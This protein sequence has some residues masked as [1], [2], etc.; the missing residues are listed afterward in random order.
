MKN[1]IFYDDLTISDEF[2]KHV[3]KRIKENPKEFT[4]YLTKELKEYPL[5]LTLDH[6]ENNE[7]TKE[8]DEI[9]N[10]SDDF[11]KQNHF[12]IF[13]CVINCIITYEKST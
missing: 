7:Q 9:L 6:V 4:T 3:E 1:L 10:P 13:S 12:I 11:Y 2:S 5:A 8:K